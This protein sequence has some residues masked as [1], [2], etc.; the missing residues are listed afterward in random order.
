MADVSRERS[1]GLRETRESLKQ[2]MQKRRP[3]FSEAEAF[4]LRSLLLDEPN[5]AEEEP[6]LANQNGTK[7]STLKS[8]SGEI[9]FSIPPANSLS[10]TRTELPDH[11][12]PAKRRSIV[13]LWKA[14]E[15]GV[16]PSILVKKAAIAAGDDPLEG[17]E[18]I[19]SEDKK[20]NKDTECT[21]EADIE[22]NVDDIASD[23]E[24]RPDSKSD[25]SAASSWDEDDHQD[26]FDTW[27]VSQIMFVIP[28][29]PLRSITYISFVGQVLK[30]EYAGDFG[31]DYTARGLTLE[32]ILSEDDTIGNTFSILGTSADDPSVQPHVLSPPLMDAI[33]NFLPEELEGQNFW[34]RYSLVRD[35][36]SLDTLRNYTKAA[37]YTIVAI[38]TPKGEVFG[39]FTS[40]PWRTNL[41]FF[42]GQP[43]FVWKMRH[44]RR[45]KCSS[46]YE[47]A[48][49]ESEIDVFMCTHKKELVQ[50]C[51]HDQLAVGGDEY[52]EG[53]ENES[54]ADENGFAFSLESDLLVG[55]TSPC[56]SFTSPALV[57]DGRHS[58]V[59]DVAGLEVWSFTPCFD[60][61]SAQKLEMTKFFIEASLRSSTQS[62]GTNSARSL[63]QSA[64]NSQDLISK[65]FYQRVGQDYESQERRNRWQYTNM[66][67]PI[68]N[69]GI[70]LQTSP[71]FT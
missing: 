64:F 31:F 10:E 38:E 65:R 59:F 26:N 71:R 12:K 58:R 52:L 24:V 37:K 20:E 4:F 8:L 33:A 13:A 34:L 3:S 17:R 66:M 14:H 22:D 9:L 7:D 1:M 62:Y 11:H 70:G 28:C 25:A 23:L 39:S 57:G 47:Q 32:S 35:G 6:L 48:Q 53:N 56:L 49:L 60:I 18:V 54:R 16:H 50:V 29:I 68:S 44:N 67:N 19:T 55:T 36:A 40:S 27:E 61:P 43:S 41:G 46:L 5:N 63:S 30:D 51:R 42:G 45:S 15:K 21:D 69:T 2:E